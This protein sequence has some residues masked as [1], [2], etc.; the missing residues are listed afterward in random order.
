MFHPVIYF[1]TSL[2]DNVKFF[3]ILSF[4]VKTA[5]HFL[6]ACPISSVLK[7]GGMSVLPT[8]NIPVKLLSIMYPITPFAFHFLS[9]CISDLFYFNETSLFSLLLPLL[10]PHVIPPFTGDMRN[11]ITIPIKVHAIAKKHVS[12][13][14]I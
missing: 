6:P 8:W 5:W 14:D 3:G 7:T 4:A 11:P 9:L 10:F 12:R 2:T 1:S 13:F